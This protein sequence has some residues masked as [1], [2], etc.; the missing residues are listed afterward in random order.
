MRASQ[1]RIQYLEQML[2]LT[3][4]TIEPQVVPFDLKVVLCGNR[5]LYYWLKYYDPEFNLLLKVRADFSEKLP[6]NKASMTLYARLIKS[7]ESRE[8]LLPLSREDV[9]RVSYLKERNQENVIPKASQWARST[10]CQLWR[11]VTI[12]L[13]AL[14]DHR[15]H[16]SGRFDSLQ[17]RD[18]NR[19]ADVVSCKLH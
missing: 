9:A 3:T 7:V 15:N 10:R 12:P 1:I 6:L 5:L 13:A 17:R 18:G 2:S 14:K 19:Q 16:S 11:L 4:T 8:R